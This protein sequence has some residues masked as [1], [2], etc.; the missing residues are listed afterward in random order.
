MKMAA[1]QMTLDSV[2]FDKFRVEDAERQ[3]Q[4]RL[5]SQHAGLVVESSGPTSHI[6]SEIERARQTIQ[7]SLRSDFLGV[8]LSVGVGVDTAGV[9]NQRIEA[10]EKENK[11]LREVTEDLRA[12]VS[13]LIARVTALEKSA[14]TPQVNGTKEAAK[15]VEAAG[16][17]DDDDDFNLD[18][19]DDE[20]A[21]EVAKLKAERLAAYAA[22]KAKKPAL[23]AKSNIILDV[24][25]WD[26]ETDMV[27]LE[28][29]VREVSTDGLKWGTGKLMPVAYGIK[30]LQISCV[31]EDDKVGTD[32]LEEEITALE[33]YV[34]SVDVVAFNK[35]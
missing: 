2:W 27:E 19:S 32:F 21:E 26:D 12:S 35:I 33:D 28:R 31:V 4:E 18:D 34:Q 7:S 5:A 30:K 3:Y 8:G 25:P 20:D 9:S 24:K 14:G 13:M 22:K 10:V 15:A 11:L 16:D 1:H 6:V 23:I 29:Q 17:D